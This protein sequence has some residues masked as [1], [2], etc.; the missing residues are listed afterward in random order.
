MKTIIV[1]IQFTL[2]SFTALAQVN[3]EKFRADNDSTG[4]SGNVDISGTAMTGNTD[5]QIING[6]TR[7]NY[8]WGQSYTFFVGSAGYGWQDKEAFSNQALAHLRHVQ[9]L[10]DFLQMEYFLQFDYN[11]K[12]LLLSR[13]LAG[14][15][16]R[17]KLFSEK[18]IKI[19]YGLA[20]MFE[21][22]EYDLPANSVHDRITDANR[23]SSYATFNILLKDG[24]D[25]ISVTY[26]QPK[27]TGWN[28]YKAI[29]DNSF[30]SELSELLDITF[31]V[32]LRYDSRP[33]DTIKRLDTITK[34]GFSFKF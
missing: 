34:F 19:R 25:F 21:H 24:F 16:V 1:L 10:S 9:S 5:F 11:K 4:F 12:R 6:D 32:S 29:S 23:L 8:N 14:I 28:D 27:I 13:E 2:I 33:P 3:T 7:L 26:F 15:G 22:E 31:G 30:I 18:S 17:L 20:Y